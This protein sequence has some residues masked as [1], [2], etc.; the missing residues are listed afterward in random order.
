MRSSGQATL[1]DT[2]IKLTSLLGGGLL[3]IYLLGFLTTRG[4]ARAVWIGIAFTATFTLWTMGVFPERFTLPFDTYYTAA[5]GNLLMFALGY[6]L[7][8]LLPAGER[9]LSGLTIWHGRAAEASDTSDTEG[10]A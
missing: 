8:A 9:D 2:S 3:G 6:G 1:Q 10:R 4:D 5:I 7:G